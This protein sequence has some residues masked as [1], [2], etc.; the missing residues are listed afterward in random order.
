MEQ[1]MSDSTA[2]GQ[3]GQT[4]FELGRILQREP[5]TCPLCRFVAQ[6]MKQHVDALFYERVTD[7]PTRQAIREARGFCRRHARLVSL[8]ADALG[9]TLIMEDILSN[10]LRDLEAGEY[11]QPAAAG[12][13]FSRLLTQGIGQIVTQTVPG[14]ELRARQ[15]RC[16]LC[17]AER[18]MD[19]VAVDGLL[20]GLN[21]HDFAEQI[22]GS[23]G[24]CMPHFQLAFERAKG[25]EGWEILLE[26]QKRAVTRLVEELGK[27]A[28]TFDYRF[29]DE[30]KDADTRSWRR[31]LDVTS[32][33]SH[34]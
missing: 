23:S 32:G 26:V 1:I 14:V 2:R 19:A 33:S 29:R 4:P 10:D 25:G 22:R 3:L 11:D 34:D 24:L 21:N 7:V 18:E 15:A 31:A 16:P 28:R 27:L 6:G 5:D 20:Q 17:E 13:S 30:A 9:T 12:G 8:Q